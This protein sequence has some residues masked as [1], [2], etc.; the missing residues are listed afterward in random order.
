MCKGSDN[1][2]LMCTVT[3]QRSTNDSVFAAIVERLT[4]LICEEFQHRGHK[5]LL[6]LVMKM[7][8][9]PWLPP[10]GSL[11][12]LDQWIISV[13]VFSDLSEGI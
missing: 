12:S 4:L 6:L 10:F 1:R 11:L 2:L 13:G 7:I 3:S 9:P 5:L 8:C